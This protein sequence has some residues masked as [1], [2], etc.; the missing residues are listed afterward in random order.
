MPK[1]SKAL[2]PLAAKDIA[3][4]WSKV[5][6]TPGHGPYGD[7]WLWMPP[8]GDAGYGQFG[9]GKVGIEYRN[10]K[11]HRIAYFLHYGEDPHPLLACHTCDFKLCCNGAHLFKGT[12]KDNGSDCAQ[13]GRTASGEKQGG[14]KLSWTSVAAIRL[15][16]AEGKI[17]PKKLGDKFGVA[18][19]TIRHII[20]SDTW[21]VAT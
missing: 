15:I 17:S 10:V 11:A 12:S 20:A 19:T 4:F 7:C 2:L 8:P 5:D 9:Y 14:A 1:P 3:R 6:K 18:R 13:K 16:Y 21:K